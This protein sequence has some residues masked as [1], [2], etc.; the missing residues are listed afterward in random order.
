MAKPGVIEGR[1][2]I[3]ASKLFK[4]FQQL[5]VR[6]GAQVYFSGSGP[7]IDATGGRHRYIGGSPMG[8]TLI[9]AWKRTTVLGDGSEKD[10][11]N[12]NLLF[13]GGFNYDGS[14]E[15]GRARLE[16]VARRIQEGSATGVFPDLSGSQGL[17][18]YLSRVAITA[19]GGAQDIVGL[20]DNDLA[21]VAQVVRPQTGDSEFRVFRRRCCGRKKELAPLNRQRLGHSDERLKGRYDGL[22]ATVR[23]PGWW[24][25]ALVEIYAANAS[26][27]PQPARSQLSPADSNVQF[28]RDI[29]S[30]RL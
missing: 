23:E 3:P 10:I 1:G 4:L 22:M 11:V 21:Y 18:V 19:A 26:Q 29:M 24:L 15:V 6:S 28:R 27:Q 9:D 17:D 14:Q 12:L 2:E 30:S 7:E 8:Y 13:M 20:C 5:F 16:A 25:N